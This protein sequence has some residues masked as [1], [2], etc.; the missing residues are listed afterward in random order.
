MY[1]LLKSLHVVSVTLWMGGMI[2]APAVA[3]ALPGDRA[4][5]RAREA[6]FGWYR[7]VVTPAMIATLALGLTLAQWAGWFEAGWL[8]AK[9][10]LVL[11]MT[12]L[13]GAISGRLRRGALLDEAGRSRLVRLS[14]ASIVLLLGIAWLAVAKMALW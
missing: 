3:A 8:Q 7:R 4:G 5:R 9:L 2:A 12:A 13:H 1:E 14:V 6:L 11:G 10:V